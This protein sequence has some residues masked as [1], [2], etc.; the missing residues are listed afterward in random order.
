MNQKLME[1]VEGQTPNFLKN[2]MN[3]RLAEADQGT[4]VYSSRNDSTKYRI[5]YHAR[6]ENAIRISLSLFDDEFARR[7]LFAL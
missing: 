3:N 7:D 5:E 1:R 4:L 6:L 2:P